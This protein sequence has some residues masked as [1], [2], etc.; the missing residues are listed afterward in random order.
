MQIIQ[1]CHLTYLYNNGNNTALSYANKIVAIN[2]NDILTLNISLLNYSKTT[3]SH[4]TKAI[5]QFFNNYNMN[6]KVL[7]F[8]QTLKNIHK[9]DNTKLK[10]Y[11]VDNKIKYFFYDKMTFIELAL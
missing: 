7:E 10:N 9:K 11:L 6:K 8:Y 2:D 5:N 3:S 1:K 4:Y